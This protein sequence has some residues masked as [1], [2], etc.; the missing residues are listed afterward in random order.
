MRMQG[1]RG[2]PAYLPVVDQFVSWETEL[3][4]VSFTPAVLARRFQ[5]KALSLFV[6]IDF[7]AKECLQTHC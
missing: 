3:H 7:V 1:K 5:A 6:G 4:R 2:K